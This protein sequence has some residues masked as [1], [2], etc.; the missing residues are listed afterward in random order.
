MGALAVL[1]HLWHL[2]NSVPCTMAQFF[3]LTL[4]G[5]TIALRVEDCDGVARAM[6]EMDVRECLSH[7]VYRGK[8]LPDNRSLEPC[9]VRNWSILYLHFMD[10]MQVIVRMPSGQPISLKVRGEDMI[11]SLKRETEQEVRVSP[12]QQQH[13]ISSSKRLVDGKALQCF[14][15]HT[16]VFFCLPC[17]LITLNVNMLTGESFTVE[18]KISEPI[19]RVK[20]KIQDKT[21]LPPEQ[22]RLVHAG[23]LVDD[24]GA[25]SDYNIQKEATVYLIRRVRKYEIFIKNPKTS[26][27]FN[28][29]VEGSYTIDKLKAM[30]EAKKGVSQR[31]QKLIF[32]GKPLRDRRTLQHYS[33]VS[34]STLTLILRSSAI[35]IFEFLLTL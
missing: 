26:H 30:V 35:Q 16:G 11:R 12:D 18:V 21:G 27:T 14:N 15:S 6:R 33:I 1:G 4:S 3:L 19:E 13:N 5:K 17:P 34:G 31:K 23:T 2:L 25:L 24:G 10:A 20:R 32:C 7:L 28:L 9:R 22:Q 8:E 29:R